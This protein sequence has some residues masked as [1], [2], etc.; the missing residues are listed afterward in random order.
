MVDL[1]LYFEVCRDL[2]MF[3]DLNYVVFCVVS[4]YRVN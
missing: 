3:F 4:R 2:E 1:Y